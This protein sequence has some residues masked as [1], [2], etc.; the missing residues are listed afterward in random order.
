VATGKINAA[1]SKTDM[2]NNDGAAGCGNAMDALAEYGRHGVNRAKLSAGNSWS[3]G[4]PEND[5]REANAMTWTMHK[6]KQE[7]IKTFLER[8]DFPPAMRE[9]LVTNGGVPISSWITRE[10]AVNGDGVG[11]ERWGS[12]RRGWT[13][14]FRYWHGGVWTKF[15]ARRPIG[16]SYNWVDYDPT[17]MT[18]AN[19]ALG[20]VCRV[21]IDDRHRRLSSD[22]EK[23]VRED[24]TEFLINEFPQ[25]ERAVA[26]YPKSI[27]FL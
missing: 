21:W 10:F 23:R 15:E 24:I 9:F 16:G 25:F 20:P 19:F 22:E 7:D 11:I 3:N 5:V 26:P 2:T 18:F 17:G 14:M 1:W 8:G 6:F 27:V 13:T 4:A 12:S